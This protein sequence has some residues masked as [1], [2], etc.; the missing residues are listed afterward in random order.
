M[1]Q[2][3]YNCFTAFAGI[4]PD[5]RYSLSTYINASRNAVPGVQN[6]SISCVRNVL[7]DELELNQVMV[8]F[9][10]SV[11]RFVDCGVNPTYPSPSCPQDQ[12]FLT[13]PPRPSKRYLDRAQ[14]QIKMKSYFTLQA[15]NWK[16]KK[17][18]ILCRRIALIYITYTN[19]TTIQQ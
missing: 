14:Q 10:S 15:L 1:I 2:Q 7:T 8:C 12:I 9:S 5:N 13:R 3:S 4:E 18:I 17:L 16:M 6:F 11:S 19:M